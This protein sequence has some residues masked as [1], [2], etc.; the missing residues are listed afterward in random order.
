MTWTKVTTKGTLEPVKRIHHTA[1]VL[2]NKM[3]LFGGIISEQDKQHDLML[4]DLEDLRWD[5]QILSS[6]TKSPPSLMGHTSILSDDSKMWVVGGKYDEIVSSLVYTLETGI[7]TAV[8]PIDFGRSNLPNEMLFAVDNKSLFTDM[9]LEYNSQLYHLHRAI[10]RIRCVAFYQEYTR[11]DRMLQAQQAKEQKPITIELVSLVSRL[12]KRKDI[13]INISKITH[14]IVLSL[15]EFIYTDA[16]SKFED[17]DDDLIDPSFVDTLSILANIFALE[18]LSAICNS[19]KLNASTQAIPPPTLFNDMAH[20]LVLCHNPNEIH[21]ESTEDIFESS[22]VTTGD[23]EFE[24]AAEPVLEPRTPMSSISNISLSSFVEK[25]LS[26]DQ[27]AFSDVIFLVENE[28]FAAHRWLLLCR[29]KFFR[30]MFS[31]QHERVIEITGIKPSI[32][33]LVL[34]YIYVGNVNVPYDAAVELLI[35][36][37]VYELERLSLMSQSVLERRLHV[38]NVCRI[39]NIADSYDIEHLRHACVFFVAHHL[40]Q[41]KKTTAYR[42]ELDWEV[43]MELK[44]MRKEVR[45][46]QTGEEE[47]LFPHSNFYHDR[48]HRDSKKGKKGVKK[49]KKVSTAPSK[50][51]SFTN[52]EIERLED[53]SPEINIKKKKKSIRKVVA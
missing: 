39:L 44:R 33:R 38:H 32:F 20:L 45:A 47:F 29:S 26:N 46:E 7:R 49:G 34:E 11:I 4:L 14:E 25:V 23:E 50:R 22:S 12:A 1:N 10:I 48:Y 17:A 19:H 53:V 21:I 41:V 15:L 24:Q 42:K 5:Y 30:R 16:I 9:M 51:K 6:D 35:A 43:K 36:A 40:S 8:E 28:R 27:N 13:Q 52:S 31:A 3:I 37:E 2:A 18:R